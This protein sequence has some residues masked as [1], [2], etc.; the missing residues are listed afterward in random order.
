M[1]RIKHF[2]WRICNHI[3]IFL[4]LTQNC[5]TVCAGTWLHLI[6]FASLCITDSIEVENIDELDEV[7]MLIVSIKSSDIWPSVH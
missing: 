4:S 3:D 7:N 6:A 2:V 5:L 1:L